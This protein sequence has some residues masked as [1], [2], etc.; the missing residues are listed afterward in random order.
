M[1]AGSREIVAGSKLGNPDV[2]SALTSDGSKI[3]DWGKYSSQTIRG[4]SGNFQV[5]F[6]M[7]RTT[8]TVNYGYDYKIVFGGGG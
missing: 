2:I 1:I 3:G 5:H 7:N 8:G 4:P 6:Y